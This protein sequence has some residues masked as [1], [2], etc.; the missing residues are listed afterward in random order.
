MSRLPTLAVV[1]A[2]LAVAGCGRANAP[3]VGEVGD[4]AEKV[5]VAPGQYDEFYA[6]LSG[7]FNG[8]VAVYGLPSGRLLKHSRSSRRTPR[9]A[10]ATTSRP[11]R[12]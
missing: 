5:Y 12:C 4:A 6:F 8:Q 1:L 11:S 2:S 3:R 7:G 10:G 9:T